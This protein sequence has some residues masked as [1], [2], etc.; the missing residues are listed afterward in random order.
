VLG[1]AGSLGDRWWLAGAPV[2]AGLFAAGIFLFGFVV[3][4][5][6]HDVKRSSLR[7]DIRA[8]EER[9]G[10]RGTPVRVQDVS[11]T[12]N[13]A[14]A[15]TN[16]FGPSTNVVLWNTILVKPFTPAEI[17]VVVAHELGH[18]AHRHILKGVGW[19]ALLALPVAW[20]LTIAARL[21]GG[22]GDPAAL[23]FVVLVLVALNFL[24]TPV[25]NVVSRRYEAEADWSALKSTRDAASARKLFVD[26]QRTSLQQPN[27]PTWDYLWLEDH[28]TIAQR[29][30]MVD[31]WLRSSAGRPS[32]AGS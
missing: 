20:F 15:A 10:V 2:F 4:I 32:R 16:G 27:P 14:N 6:T 18:V 7:A 24:A 13:L 29:I 3:Q 12:T 22:I 9:E 17:R 21:R 5:G 26:F 11:G 30:A 28:P 8:L 19:I 31:A 1:L 25:V 23:P